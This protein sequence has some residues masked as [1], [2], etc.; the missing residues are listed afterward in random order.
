M[1]YKLAMFIVCS[2]CLQLVAQGAL[3]SNFFQKKSTSSEGCFQSF[4]EKYRKRYKDN[5]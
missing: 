3:F 1:T 5:Q 4:K 2:F